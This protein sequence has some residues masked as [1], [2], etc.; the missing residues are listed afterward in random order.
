MYKFLKPYINYKNHKNAMQSQ[1]SF[2]ISVYSTNC[3]GKQNIQYTFLLLTYYLV[4]VLLSHFLN[5]DEIVRFGRKL[6]SFNK[7]KDVANIF[8]NFLLIDQ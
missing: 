7:T 4:V 2:L 5:F 1:F 3:Q 6:I 8:S